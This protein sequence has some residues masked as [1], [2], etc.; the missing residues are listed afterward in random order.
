MVPRRGLE[1]PRCYPLVPETSASTNSAI[2]A[3]GL[4]LRAARAL[5][6]VE[7]SPRCP[8]LSP[9]FGQRP[10]ASNPSEDFAGAPLGL[11]LQLDPGQ[12]RQVA[13]LG[14]RRHSA[15]TL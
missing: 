2:W 5:V 15:C 11:D 7:P 6:N 3:G 4:Q 8:T 13:E 12:P 1:P 10:S 9:L 14:R